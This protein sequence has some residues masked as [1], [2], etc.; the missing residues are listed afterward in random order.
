MP[1]KLKRRLLTVK[2]YHQMG[3]VG[4]LQENGLELIKGE[5]LEMSPIGSKHAATVEII[6]DLLHTYLSEK[7][8]I[9]TQNPI[10]LDI[11]SEPEPDIALV[12]FRDDYYLHQHPQ[13]QDTLLLIE[14]ASSSLEFDREIKVPLYAQ[15]GIPELWIVDLEARRVEVFHTPSGSR[16]T[17]NASFTP[18]DTIITQKISLE[19]PVDRI[20][21]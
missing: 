6:R 18:S 8:L 7:V 19:I 3:E 5:I 13:A 11:Y 17:H 9:R 2:E 15:A 20:F 1:V 10:T 12:S 4:I 16:Y 14:V 21:I